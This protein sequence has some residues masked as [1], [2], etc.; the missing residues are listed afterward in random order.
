[1]TDGVRDEKRE[2]IER[3]KGLSERRLWC[4]LLSILSKTNRRD[5][6]ELRNVYRWSEGFVGIH[7][8]TVYKD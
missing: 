1:M 3:E 8:V 4:F 5:F 6:R 2:G 7:A